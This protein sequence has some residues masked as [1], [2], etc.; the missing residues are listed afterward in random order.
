MKNL[1][2]F[3]LIISFSLF[4]SESRSIKYI[5]DNKRWHTV[6]FDVLTGNVKMDIIDRCL[7]RYYY[8]IIEKG[9]LSTPGV[10]DIDGDG[11]AKIIVCTA[12]EY[13]NVL[14]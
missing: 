12:D 13:I 6:I 7:R 5:K 11:L 10:A 2:T 1:L 8:H 3:L 9:F 4:C 14:K